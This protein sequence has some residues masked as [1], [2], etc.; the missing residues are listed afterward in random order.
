MNTM[1]NPDSITPA[2]LD[3]KSPATLDSRKAQGACIAK[4]TVVKGKISKCKHIAV[5]GVVEGDLDVGHIIIHQDGLV[6][7]TITA[8][9]IEVHGQFKGDITVSGLCHISSSGALSG[10][11]SYG[12]LSLENGGVLS[13]QVSKKS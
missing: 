9:S 1:V 5:Y 3:L 13:A 11:L 10:K 6:D 7:G 2:P 12:K 4:D 8:G